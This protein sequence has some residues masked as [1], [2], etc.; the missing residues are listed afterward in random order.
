M[1]VGVERVNGTAL[2]VKKTG[3]KSRTMMFV[4]R[5]DCI[6]IASKFAEA[7]YV[8]TLKPVEVYERGQTP[9]GLPW[10]QETLRGLDFEA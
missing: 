2:E 7:G 10:K 5:E 9:P 1:G 8:C 4:D 6:A 3:E